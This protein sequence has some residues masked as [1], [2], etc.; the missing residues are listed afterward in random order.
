M[1]GASAASAVPKPAVSA[2][3]QD[4]GPPLLQLTTEPPGTVRF[5]APGVPALWGIGVTTRVARLDTLVGY[6]R[7]HGALTALGPHT[8]VE[9][10]SCTQPWTAAGCAAGPRSILPATA[11]DRLTQPAM[12]LT[13]PARA[14]PA[15]VYLRARILLAADAPNAVQGE[16]ATVVAAVSASGI[17]DAD[18]PAVPGVHTPAEMADT[19]TDLLAVALLGAAAV[20]AGAIVAGAARRR[21]RGADHAA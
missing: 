11:I 10:A 21:K 6:L 18:T 17:A 2:I 9:L 12:P 16:S 14:I 8:T 4:G 19:G 13:D 7:A 3:A 1:L 5:L 15:H 20:G